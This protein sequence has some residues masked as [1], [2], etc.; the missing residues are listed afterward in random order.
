MP[1]VSTEHPVPEARRRAASRSGRWLMTP[2]LWLIMAA[3]ASATHSAGS[4][5]TYTYL[6]GNNYMVE[7]TFY[8][9]CAGIAEPVSMPVSYAS[10]SCG[11]A[12]TAMAAKVGGSGIEIT[13]PCTS[14]ASSC[15]GGIVTGIQKFVY[16]AIVTLPAACTD[17]IFSYQVCCR[18][19]SITTLQNPCAAGSNLYVEALLN[20]LQAPGNSSP[21]F[22]NDPV[23]F[24]CTGQAFHYNPGIIEND[25]DSL[26][27][28]LI[29]PKTG[30][31]S[32]VVYQSG[33]SPL[34]PFQSNIPLTL[35]P[36]NGQISITPGQA[37]IG[38]VTLRINEFRNGLKIGS[39]IRDM[40][41]Y[42]T[43]CANEQ[44]GATGI[45]GT[46]A[47]SVEATAGETLC[48]AVHTFD[49]DA[50]QQLTV[51]FNN[52]IPGAQVNVTS[53]KHPDVAFCWTPDTTQIRNTPF[54]FSITV[55]DDACPV[56]G[57]QVFAYSI[58]VRPGKTGLQAT[59]ISC[60]G[61][62]D[63]SARV[64]NAATGASFLWSTGATTD[65][66]TSLAAGTYSVT[67]S[68]AGNLQ[69]FTCQVQDPMPVATSVIDVEPVHCHGGSDGSLL[70][71][72][73]GGVP[74][75]AYAW[76]N[77]GDEGTLEGLAA[78]TY[79]YTVTDA[80]GCTAT[81][82]ATVTEPD[83]ALTMNLVAVTDATCFGI[84]DGHVFVTT[85]GGTSPYAYSLNNQSV[86]DLSGL[87]AGA[88][89]LRSTDQRG[90][91]DEVS[92]VVGQ[93]DLL[94][95]SVTTVTPVTCH[96]GHDGSI[97][98]GINGGTGPY[99]YLWSN[100]AS[101][102]TAQDLVAATYQA[103][104]TDA[105]GCTA[106]MSQAVKEPAALLVKADSIA[107]VSCFA[108]QNGAVY[109]IAEGGTPPYQ[110]AWTGGSSAQALTQVP[111]GQ[112][113]V[114]VTDA[115]GCTSSEAFTVSQPAA[116]LSLLAQVQRPVSCFGG[117]NGIIGLSVT[118]GT[119]PYR[120]LW[121]NGATT[122][123]LVNVPAGSY[124]VT[125]TDASTCTGTVS[126]ALIQPAAALKIASTVQDETE[127]SGGSNGAIDITPSNGQA[128]YRYA[129]NTGATTEDI[130]HLNAGS[131]SVT[132]TDAAG[133]DA[134]TTF[135]VQ[136]VPSGIRISHQAVPANCL[137][138][139]AGSISVAVR[140]GEPP[141]A[142]RWSTG[143]TSSG[144]SGIFKGTYALTITDASACETSLNIT[145]DDTGS[146]NARPLGPTDIC[147]G[148]L[149]MIMADTVFD[150]KYQW[151]FDGEPLTGSIQQVYMAPKEGNY[152][153]SVESACGS[154]TSENIP[155]T[156]LTV[157]NYSI[158][159]NVILCPGEMTRLHATGGTA[160]RWSP[161]E[162]LDYTDIPDPQASPGETTTYHVEVTAGNACKATGDVMVSVMC[163]TVNIPSGFSPNGDGVNDWFVIEGL[164]AYRYV[165][166]WIYNRRGALVYKSGDYD[167]RW[168]GDSNVGMEAGKALT[169][170]TYY[171]V[172]DL[173]EGK[174]PDSGYVVLRR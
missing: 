123:D 82:S 118:E 130:G 128:P 91:A 17:W 70:A 12:L 15:N 87:A 171:Y 47:Y 116:P 57:V 59:G 167:N 115:G 18:N 6:G 156:V 71:H 104:V 94:D 25:G 76:N 55:K 96:G 120:Y 89:T 161:P 38:V 16:Q 51:T 77:G 8:R 11:F 95:L 114:T 149:V 150:G 54:T 125:V 26:G 140:G 92:F 34:N 32:Q 126:V 23:A 78:G 147:L 56:N 102:A 40:Q 144:I 29:A 145:L 35:N 133:C 98:T 172:L 159:P 142:Y 63:G 46:T 127:C 174:K 1:T 74:P 42:A 62:T 28:E 107:T 141:Y 117:S 7:V 143:T 146:F 9:D 66:I 148:D 163:D 24:V 64:V 121:S 21:H 103:T 10:A 110:Y 93:P 105:H 58:Y 151:F 5:L 4:D 86:N 50:G 79:A 112:Y 170:G 84:S 73:T 68:E 135:A 75:Y 129:W 69:T 2:L 41:L 44:P 136:L 119:P 22:T 30:P 122:Q 13:A 137:R 49:N 173:N 97:S 31:Q 166:I 33:Y 81:A 53:G 111:A 153:V 88:Y 52:P 157:E 99:Q 109:A 20:N 124:A 45:N 158:S 67:V 80:N 113:A 83:S 3:P 162:G 155:V 61:G 101:T 65:A 48:F 100:G 106:G 134:A 72:T 168:N 14:V 85:T 37:Q 90:C 36:A 160:Y 154:F 132:V 39:V 139:T 43:P 19:C 152:T 164:D 131:Y 27:Y 165:K 60:H 169:A 138:N 108:G